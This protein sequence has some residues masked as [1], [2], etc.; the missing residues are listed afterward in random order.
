MMIDLNLSQMRVM[1][2]PKLRE[3][4]RHGGNFWQRQLETMCF[5]SPRHE[6]KSYAS[7]ADRRA[8]DGEHHGV[9]H[10]MP[11]MMMMWKKKNQG[12]GDVERPSLA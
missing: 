11:A 4:T 9:A 10:P 12:P 8:E 3:V 5:V 2:V 6:L 7:S 1:A